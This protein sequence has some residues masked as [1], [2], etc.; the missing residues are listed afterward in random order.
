MRNDRDLMRIHLETLFTLDERARMICVNEV[1]GKAAPRFFLGR[2]AEGSEWR[3]R[4]DLAAD[5]VEELEAACREELIG[6]EFLVPPYGSVR[7]EALLA[8]RAAIEKRWAGPAYRFP[9][10]IAPPSEVIVITEKNSDLIGSRMSAWSDGIV[11]G[12]PFL[13]VIVADEVVSVCCS[14]RTT[15]TAHEAG[16]ETAE[17]FRGRGYGARVVGAWARAVRDLDRIP[18]YSTSWDND[19][20]RAL[21]KRLGL[22][23]F[24]TD[25]HFT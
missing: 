17:G 7:Y 13:T 3:F 9:D 18:L 16:V 23:R 19:P 2:T 21:A 12:Q 8:R 4:Y 24:G 5:L 25:L 20:S 22:V 15:S 6:E 11:V 10:R 1:A 14:L